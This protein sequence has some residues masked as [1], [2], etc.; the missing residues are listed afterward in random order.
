MLHGV[1]NEIVARL[2][3]ASRCCP[4]RASATRSARWRSSRAR[5]TSTPRKKFVDWALTAEAQ[6]IG[7]DVK[8]YAIPTNRSVPLPPQVPKLTDVKVINYDFAKYGVERHAQ[9][10]ARALGEGDQRR[11]ATRRDDRCAAPTRAASLLAGSPSA[12]PASCCVPWYALQDSV[13]A[14]R[15]ARAVRPAKDARAGAAAGRCCTA[16]PGSRRSASLLARGAALALLPA[17]AAR[18]RANALIAV[19]AAGFVYLLRAG[20]RDRPAR[21]VVRVARPRVPALAAAASTAWASAPRSSSPRSRCCSRS[22]SPARGYFKGDALRRRQRRRRRACWSPCSRSSRS[23]RI[24]VSAF[25][26]NDGAFSLAG[27][28]RPP[29]H[30]EDLGTRLP[31]R[32]HAL[33]RRLEHAAARAACARSAA[34]RSA[35]P[36]R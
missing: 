25:E 23:S 1:I 35:S 31:R 36:S 3:G 17:L 12:P 21:L 14:L 15:L 10:P 2:P 29:V 26:D 6:K 33:R 19:G 22:G 18:A 32:R 8:E 30:R 13:F 7:L 9:A 20:L 28:P 34:R 5:A 27:V 4:A 16:A 11:A 24:L